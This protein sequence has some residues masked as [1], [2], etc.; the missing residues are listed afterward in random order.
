MSKIITLVLMMFLVGCSEKSE[1]KE[2]SVVNFNEIMAEFY[3][4]HVAKEIPEI[5]TFEELLP[6]DPVELSLTYSY[7]TPMFTITFKSKEAIS[8]FLDLIEEIELEKI[9]KYGFG[10]GGSIDILMALH[11]ENGEIFVFIDS[12]NFGGIEVIGGIHFEEYNGYVLAESS[13]G[14]YDDESNTTILM[15]AIRTYLGNVLIDYKDNYN[16]LMPIHVE[17]NEVVIEGSDNEIFPIDSTN[18]IDFDFKDYGLRAYENGI[19][20]DEL[21]MDFGLHEVIFENE[22]GTF[23][24][25]YRSK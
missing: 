4:T 5:I 15:S 20:I 24:L 18:L 13:S 1:S 6:I 9:T 11:D 25:N 19:E 12:H 14:A 22:Y 16:L 17:T 3:L 21:P 2:E 7:V 8:D 10:A 23:K